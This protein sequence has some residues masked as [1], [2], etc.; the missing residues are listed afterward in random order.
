[1]K[2]LINLCFLTFA[3]FIISC[4][5]PDPC[6]D[7]LCGDQGACD[8]G[9]CICEAGYEQDAD[10]LCNTE[11]RAKF[12]GNYSLVENC[13]TGSDSYNCAI[14]ASSQG[15]MKV[16]LSNL[17]NQGIAVT[18]DMINSTEFS[19]PAGTTFGTGTISGTGK[20]DNATGTVSITVTY[21]VDNPVLGVDN[22]VATLSPL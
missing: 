2:N 6:K 21:E 7:V 13:T 15:N 11:M 3:L 22:C 19:I 5:D 20:Y 17:Y 16:V 14:A 10:G 4:G 8:D 9:T 12:I 18:A 1:M